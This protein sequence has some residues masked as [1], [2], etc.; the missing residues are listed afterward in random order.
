MVSFI[1]SKAMVN[2]WAL[3][4]FLDQAKSKEIIVTIQ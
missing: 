1:F 2:Y 4:Y 3:A